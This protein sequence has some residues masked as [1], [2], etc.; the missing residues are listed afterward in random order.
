MICLPPTP[1]AF[2]NPLVFLLEVGLLLTGISCSVPPGNTRQE[3]GS[4]ETGTT[5]RVLSTDIQKILDSTQVKGSILVYDLQK[6]VYYSND[7]E[8]AEQGQL[9]ASTFKIPNSIIAL[10]TGVVE[11]DSTIFK[12]D[13]EDRYLPVWEQDLMLKEAFHYSCVPCYQEVARKVGVGQMNAYLDKF[14][15]GNMV[16]DSTNIDQFWLEGASRISPFEQIDFLTRFYKEE[17]PISP[18]TYTIMKKMIIM[19]ANDSYTLRGKT[20]WSVSKGRDNGWFVG[21]LSTKGQTYFF[22]T[23]VDPLDTF[24]MAFFAETRIKITMDALRRLMII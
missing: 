17:L 5:N 11:N 9:P 21:Y 24:N 22:A 6:K 10:E 4:L 13:G 16:V 14:E 20:G 7:F 1:Y 19:E 8:W 15:Y 23:N 12:W 3:S 2:Q 18:S